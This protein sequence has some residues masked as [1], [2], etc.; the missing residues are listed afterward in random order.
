MKQVIKVILLVMFIIS[1]CTNIAFG[2]DKLIVTTN[3]RSYK[4]T[5]TISEIEERS[6]LFILD[7]WLNSGVNLEFVTQELIGENT[8]VYYFKVV[9]PE[10]FYVFGVREYYVKAVY[11][12]KDTVISPYKSWQFDVVW[13][14]SY[15]EIQ[16][17]LEV[18]NE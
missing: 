14:S 12:F 1:F 10:Y 9:E 3:Q 13:T 7:M 11:K 16:T 8:L 15:G 2:L 5:P 17:I 18:E 4:E 6:K